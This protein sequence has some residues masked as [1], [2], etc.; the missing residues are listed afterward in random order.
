M[1]KYYLAN[2]E[3][4]TNRNLRWR[5]SNLESKRRS[6]KKWKKNNPHKARE[7][8]K[9]WKNKNP[10]KYREKSKR[11]NS[12]RKRDL[13]YKPINKKEIGNVGHHIDR[14]FVIYI[15]EELHKLVSH[16]RNDL[17]SMKEINIL[18]IQVAY[19]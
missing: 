11:H 16:S 8:E 14:D 6:S 1:K 2:K 17:E 5:K 19:I 12:K 15:P 3:K 9:N 4:I 18:A 10:E 7:Y 13:G